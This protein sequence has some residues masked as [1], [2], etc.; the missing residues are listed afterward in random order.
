MRNLIIEKNVY[1]IFSKDD[2]YMFV[3][4]FVTKSCYIM[5][6][7]SNDKIPVLNNGLFA[8]S[9]TFSTDEKYIVILLCNLKSSNL[10]KMII[11]NTKNGE[12]LYE[13]ELENYIKY[14]FISVTKLNF[15]ENLVLASFLVSE[16]QSSV[17]LTIDM[18]KNYLDIS[19]WR[20]CYILDAFC[21]EQGAVFLTVDN[22]H[23]FKQTKNLCL[24]KYSDIHKPLLKR[25]NNLV[26]RNFK[27]FTECYAI[28][29]NQVFARN[30]GKLYIFNIDSQRFILISS[31]KASSTK[32]INPSNIIGETGLFIGEEIKKRGSVFR[33]LFGKRKSKI[34]L[35]SF[36]KCEK[37]GEIVS[38]TDKCLLVC[39]GDVFDFF[40]LL[41]SDTKIKENV[42][43]V[44]FSPTLEKIVIHTNKHTYICSGD[45]FKSF[46]KQEKLITRSQ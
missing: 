39:D 30:K 1:V 19:E 14:D 35:F 8:F 2:S 7:K 9:A 34:C 25:N 23:K 36:R 33:V 11:V 6:L 18:S 40:D 29:N 4:N 41:P 45:K 12:T 37:I 16:N 22:T 24:V 21:G 46:I 44:N 31:E 20:K 3:S 5:D 28:Q 32:F 17:V 27:F 15:Y 42:V 38:A 43:S 13:V 26:A 10:E